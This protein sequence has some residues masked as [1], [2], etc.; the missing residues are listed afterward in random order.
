MGNF[1]PNHFKAYR[2]ASERLNLQQQSHTAIV[3]SPMLNFTY[4]TI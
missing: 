3:F 4:L 2:W 1:Q